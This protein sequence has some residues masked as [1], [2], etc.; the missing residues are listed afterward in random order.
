MGKIFYIMG[1]SAAGKDKIY[2]RLIGNQEL[3]LKKLILYTTRPIRD[4]E[5]NGRE[6]F[7]TDDRKLA[8]LESQGLVIEKR[9]YH[10][11]HGLWTYFTADDGQADLEK[12]DYLGIGTL[13]SFVKMR[14]YYGEEAVI[15]VYIQVETGERLTR[16]LA[17][18]KTQDHPKYAEMC[19]RFL[20][21]EED[22]SEENIYRAGIRKRFEN[23]NL[24]ICVEEIVKYIKSVQ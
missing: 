20:A 14:E 11:V 7:F 24:D 8:E 23:E 3:S 4:G 15:P 1:K 13:E 10:T 17:R 21:D 9:E 5:K 18:E 22:F 6:Y 16:A 12:S 2:S 19:R